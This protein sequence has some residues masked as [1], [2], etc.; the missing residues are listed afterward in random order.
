M[1]G[2]AYPLAEGPIFWLG[3]GQNKGNY[4][5]G[6]TGQMGTAEISCVNWRPGRGPRRLRNSRRAGNP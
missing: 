2:P 3:V 5:S 6:K 1:V 4:L